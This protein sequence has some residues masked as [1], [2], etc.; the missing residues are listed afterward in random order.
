M[1][2]SARFLFVFSLHL[3]PLAHNL[4]GTVE[5]YPAAPPIEIL[6]STAQGEVKPTWSPTLPTLT[7][8]PTALVSH[9]CQTLTVFS[10]CGEKPRRVT[11]EVT[12]SP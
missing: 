7:P 8:E 2:I 5:P 1:S 4:R 10:H 6:T 3:A 11:A 12:L 9:F